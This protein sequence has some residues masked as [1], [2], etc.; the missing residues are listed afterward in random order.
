MLGTWKIGPALAAGCTVVVKPPEWAPF[1]LS[2]LGALATEAG[3]PP[4]VLNIV[5]GVGE[6]TGAAPVAH[7]DVARISFPGSPDPAPAIRS[8]ERRV[9]TECTRTCRSR[10]SPYH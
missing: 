4:G 8:E 7:A 5:H 6:R 3:L 1:S 9:G 10:W 2:L